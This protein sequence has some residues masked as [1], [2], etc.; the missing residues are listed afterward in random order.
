MDLLFYLRVVRKGWWL[1]LLC[2]ALAA[3]A[4]VFATARATPVY[5]SSTKLYVSGQPAADVQTALA[6]SYLSAQRVKSYADLV[7]SKPVIDQVLAEAGE[8]GD[9]PSIS[10]APVTDTVILSITVRDRTPEGAMRV[11]NG[12][13]VVVPD[14]IDKLE[15]PRS[16]GTSPIKATVTSPAQLGSK[17]SPKPKLN[18]ALGLVLGLLLGGAFALLKETLDTSIKSPEDLERAAKSLALLGAVFFDGDATKNHLVTATDPRSPR[19]EAFRQLRT[20]VQFAEIDSELRS[21]VITSALPNEGKST[22]AANI[23]IALA[24]AGQRVILVEADLRRP[25]LAEY[26]GFERAVGLTNVLIGQVPLEDALQTFGA[27]PRLQIL[28]GGPVPPNPSEILGSQAMN[29]LV[30]QME[31]LVD[32]VIF[33]TPPLLPVTDAAV[34]AAQTKGALLVV[35]ANRT[36]RDQVRRSLRALEAVNASCIGAALNFVKASELSG[37][38]YG[39]GYYAGYEARKD[40]QTLDVTGPEL[41]PLRRSGSGASRLSQ[42]AV[43]SPV[44]E[45]THPAATV[46]ATVLLADA[47]ATPTPNPP[48][49]DPPD[50][51]PDRAAV[52]APSTSSR[53]GSWLGKS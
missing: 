13:G 18:L 42:P 21:F 37:Y 52:P 43:P 33:D 6:T 25:S 51:E 39:Y 23:A 44:A 46:G 40:L 28:P 17:T 47:A 34:L 11:A 12:F 1:I 22:I 48:A 9:V 30:R 50:V 2:T 7:T 32:I 36:T 5:E 20:N 29:D 31:D 16:G 14:V 3:G 27:E 26:M 10:A 24:Q 53:L 35:R 38:K 4:A 41:I 15:R 8:P 19:A 49:V 45:G